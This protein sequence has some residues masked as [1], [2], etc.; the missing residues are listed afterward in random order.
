MK[1]HRTYYT[2][3]SNNKSESGRNRVGIGQSEDRI[4]RSVGNGRSGGV[5]RSVGTGPAL[6]KDSLT[7]G[8]NFLGYPPP[9]PKYAKTE[10]EATRRICKITPSLPPAGPG[11]V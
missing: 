8:A 3:Y 4:G 9:G 7:H 10:G 11:V 6:G 5:G 1:F 2:K